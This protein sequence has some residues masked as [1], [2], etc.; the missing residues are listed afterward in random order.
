MAVE[1]V[2]LLSHDEQIVHFHILQDAAERHALGHC[3]AMPEPFFFGHVVEFLDQPTGHGPG[4]F[5]HLLTQLFGVVHAADAAASRTGFDMAGVHDGQASDAGI[6]LTG[7]LGGIPDGNAG[8]R[9][10]IESDKNTP[11]HGV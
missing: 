8:V 9:I 1:E 7:K 6:V 11:D 3:I 10:G 5:R 2:R 4:F